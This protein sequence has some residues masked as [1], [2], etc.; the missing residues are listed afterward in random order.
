MNQKP[1]ATQQSLAPPAVLVN[2]PP[3]FGVGQLSQLIGLS[4]KTIQ[5][6]RTIYRKKP[7]KSGRPRLP[8]ACTPPDSNTPVWLLTDVLIWLASHRE[9]VAVQPAS[10]PPGTHKP[11]VHRAPG[12]LGRPTK[13]EEAEADAAGLT[14]KQLRA[15]KGGAA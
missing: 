13:V 3:S 7:T 8:P 11:R 4:V 10:L 5:T 1:N 12:A 14:V 9:A 6:Y 15:Q 2:F